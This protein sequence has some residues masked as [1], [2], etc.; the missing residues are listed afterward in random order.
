LIG[1]DLVGKSVGIIGTGKIGS[2]AAQIFSGLGCQIL[3]H[4]LNPD[5]TLKKHLKNFSY[6]GLDQLFSTADIISLHLPLTPQTH[7]LINAKAIQQMKP[8][9]ML[10]N[11]GRGALID[12]KALIKGL[13]TGKIGSAGLDVYEEEENIFFK[14]FSDQVLQDDVLARLL[15][16]PN[17]LITAHQGYLTWEAL[18]HIAQTTLENI[19]DFEKGKPLNNEVLAEEVIKPVAKR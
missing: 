7:H 15:T 1:F 17:V 3:A 9:V 4:D 10:I 6:T 12:S 18:H 8:G 5:P 11:T 19:H 2:V 16:F 13:K 14:D